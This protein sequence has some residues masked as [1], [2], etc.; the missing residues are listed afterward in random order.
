M[1]HKIADAV[2]I[3]TV[4][5]APQVTPVLTDA[6]KF[7]LRDAQLRQL[8]AEKKAFVAQQAHQ[9]TMMDLQAAYQRIV[10]ELRV[11]TERFQLKLETLV[12]EEL[13]KTA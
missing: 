6:H 9:R 11:D 3:D 2:A 4:T 7:S 12:F 5:P 13:P 8:D 1:E 10:A